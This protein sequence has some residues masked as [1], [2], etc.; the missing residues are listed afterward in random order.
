MGAKHHDPTPTQPGVF[1]EHGPAP[2]RPWQLRVVFWLFLGIAAFY[3]ITEHR[4][5]LVAGLRWL[6][7][8]LLAACPLMHMF[9]HRGHRGHGGDGG[10]GRHE[11]AKDMAANDSPQ[12]APD[13]DIANPTTSCDHQHGGD[14]P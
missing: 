3:L 8:L 1:H 6:P 4:A 5:H 11:G 9:G 14:S 13:K 10:R 2:T 7:F 12:T